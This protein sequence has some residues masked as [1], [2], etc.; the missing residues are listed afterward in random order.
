MVYFHIFVNC[1]MVVVLVV[2]YMMMVN[3]YNMVG[4]YKEDARDSVCRV[5]VQ[6]DLRVGQ[7]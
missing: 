2:M 4:L 5:L 7:W 6:P 3:H 1:L